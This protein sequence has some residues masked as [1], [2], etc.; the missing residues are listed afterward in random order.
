MQHSINRRRFLGRSALAIGSA[1]ALH[2]G[3]ARPTRAA[4]PDALSFQLSW[5]KSPQY[6]G[7]FSGIEHGIFARHGIDAT[8]NSGGPNVDP[9]A[10][11]A[12]GR[13]QMG[14]RPIGP[15]LI[16]RDRG[17]PVR[18]I[19]TVFQ[20]SP[21]CLISR[22]SNPIK[23]L[24][25]MKGKIIS[26]ST[27]TRP[28]ILYLLKSVGLS[29]RDVT[30]VPGSPDPAALANGQTDAMAGYST[31]QG[32]ILQTRGVEIF[33]LNVQE[34]G[35]PETTG[36]I[37]ARED[38]LDQNRDIVV[39]FLRAAAESWRHCLAHPEESAKLMVEK[40]GAPGLDYK[41]ALAEVK[42]SAPFIEEGPR[43]K[44]GLLSL[45]LDLYQKIVE[46]YHGAG[47]LKNKIDV[48]DLCDSSFVEAA[49]KV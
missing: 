42:A 18:V 6:S 49:L 39:R 13:S 25:D 36:T 26:A 19:G 45:D 27:S 17:I 32:I 29:D 24:E 48:K 21:F 8:F 28:L 47:M 41:A 23:R 44:A 10:N 15:I 30:L 43:G 33:M 31:N 40:Y 20:K 14:D 12:S 38:F 35:V 9:L 4:V 5:I 46:V 37:Y 34:L 7:Y 3:G 1:A 16:A 11:V 2:L 22:A